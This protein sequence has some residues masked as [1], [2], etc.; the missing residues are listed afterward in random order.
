MDQ[1]QTPQTLAEIDEWIAREHRLEEA[2]YA[3]GDDAQAYWYV[4]DIERLHNL[5]RIVADRAP[6]AEEL[7]RA[8]RRHLAERYAHAMWRGDRDAAALLQDQI[9]R[10]ERGQAAP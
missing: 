2:A 5:R 7:R 8:Q 9:D 10:L 4:L 6:L 1:A 3:A